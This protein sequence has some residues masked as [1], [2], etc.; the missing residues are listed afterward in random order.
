LLLNGAERVVQTRVPS[1]DEPIVFSFAREE[2]RSF[3]IT[4]KNK[5]FHSRVQLRNEMG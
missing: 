1:I 3:G 2:S 4:Q 5:L